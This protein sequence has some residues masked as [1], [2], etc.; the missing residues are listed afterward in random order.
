M[1]SA[2][3][4]NAGAYV[5]LIAAVTGLSAV[6]MTSVLAFTIVKVAGAAYLFFLG[7]QTL[8]GAGKGNKAEPQL[9]CVSMQA[10]FLAGVFVGCL[11]PQGCYFLPRFPAAIR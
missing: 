9:Q 10:A 8:L 4:I 2:L 6:L 1:V 3:G 11:E 5:H 7:L